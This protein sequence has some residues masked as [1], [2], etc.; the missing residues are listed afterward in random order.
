MSLLCT[1]LTDIVHYTIIGLAILLGLI[2]VEKIIVAI[3][4]DTN[5]SKQARLQKQMEKDLQDKSIQQQSSGN[6]D[7]DGQV[8]VEKSASY[9]DEQNSFN[10]TLNEM[11]T[12]QDNVTEKTEKQQIF[13]QHVT[14]QTERYTNSYTQTEYRG[15]VEQPSEKTE[16]SDNVGNDYN[17]EY[18]TTRREVYRHTPRESVPVTETIQQPQFVS[19]A[20]QQPS[21]AEQS[22]SRIVVQPTM[23]KVVEQSTVTEQP[24]VRQTVTEQPVLQ[25]QPQQT[26]VQQ[27][28]KRTTV[29][30]KSAT[31][32]DYIMIKSGTTV[33]VKSNGKIHEG[34]YLLHIDDPNKTKFNLYY[35]NFV[36]EHS[37]GDVI[38]LVE[39]DRICPMSD[40]IYIKPYKG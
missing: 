6:A 1:M 37:D 10:Q 36:L 35:N 21:Q 33:K 26:V 12:E 18:K 31:D 9:A 4:V 20:E 16:R 5:E 15:V 40:T 7:C 13:E 23:R 17:V 27:V 30:E 2:I 8:N 22:T 38:L 28:A 34:R 32:G 14:A 11:P 25:Q 29:A 24:V 3:I 39:D 19:Q